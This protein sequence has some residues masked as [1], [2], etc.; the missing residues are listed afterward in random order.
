MKWRQ[1]RKGTVTFEICFDFNTKSCFRPLRFPVD[2][3]PL[4]SYVNSSMNAPA[5]RKANHGEKMI[6]VRVRFW[7]DEITNTPKVIVPKHAWDFGYVE[8]AA[9]ASHGLKQSGSSVKFNSVLELPQAIADLLVQ[10]GVQ[11]HIGTK[12]GKLIT[13][14][15]FDD[16]AKSG[17]DCEGTGMAPA[18]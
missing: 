12:L 16:P 4:A 14:E 13:C 15:R 8:I 9:N 5:E 11:L 6:E 10:E 7:T 17:I 2:S 1:K 3:W 18:N